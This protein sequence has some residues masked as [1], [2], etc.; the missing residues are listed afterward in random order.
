VLRGEGDF[1]I[2]HKG[3][4]ERKGTEMTIYNYNKRDGKIEREKWRKGQM[5]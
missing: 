2:Y 3:D 1:G 5:L 4:T